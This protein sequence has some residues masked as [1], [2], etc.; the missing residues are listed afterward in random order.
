[1]NVRA[2][3][4]KYRHVLRKEAG[5]TTELDYT[6]QTSLLLFLKYLDGLEREKEVEAKLHGKSR[7]SFSK[8][9]I[10]GKTGLRRKI[11][12]AKSITTRRNRAMTCAILSIKSC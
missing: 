6:E 10:G 1:M 3:L 7:H 4:Q 8:S 11:K 12:P 9:R 5:C 2:G